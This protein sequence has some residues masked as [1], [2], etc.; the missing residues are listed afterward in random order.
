LVY[1][2]QADVSILIFIP[3]RLLNVDYFYSLINFCIVAD[4][5]LTTVSSPDLFAINHNT[6][7]AYRALYF[8]ITAIGENRDKKTCKPSVNSN[9]MI[10]D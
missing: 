5:Q 1:I 10:E 6:V 7:L 9:Q 8:V 4:S 2:F 3:C